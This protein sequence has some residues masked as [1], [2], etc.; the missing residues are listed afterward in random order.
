[1]IYEHE[2]PKGSRLYFGKEAKRKREFEYGVS[3]FLGENGFEEIITPNFSYSGH[4][5]IDEETEVIKLQDENNNQLSLRADST[6]DVVRLITKR[7]GRT[8]THKKWF[9]IQPVF[10]YPANENY[11]IGCEWIDGEDI[12]TMINLTTTTL[13]RSG[14]EYVLQL[15]N[16]DIPKIVSSELG[17]DISI[18]KDGDINKLFEL[19]IEWVSALLNSSSV[20]AIETLLDI[21]PTYIKS[22]LQSMVDVAKSVDRDVVLSPF[23]YSSLTYYEGVQFKAISRHMTVAKGGFYSAQGVKSLGFALYTDNILKT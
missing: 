21:V 22:E 19:D 12:A 5:S 9:Y 17:I 13:K 3:Q 1:M 14:V 8:T 18:F 23:Y 6:L 10:S 15:S 16:I 11:Q 20:E 7:L 4:Q 2:I